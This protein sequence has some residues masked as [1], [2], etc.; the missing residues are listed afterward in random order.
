M[1]PLVAPALERL[2]EAATLVDA[3]QD[4][5]ERATIL[6][7]LLKNH[8]QELAKLYRTDGTQ[9]EAVLI[10]MRAV[11]G[12][13]GLLKQWLR[14]IKA[15]AKAQAS[16]LDARAAYET[17]GELASLDALVEPL[18]DCPALLAPPR[19]RVVPG[20]I[21]CGDDQIALEPIVV[22][23]VTRDLETS[24]IRWD[25]AWRWRG[26][27]W[28]RSV[29]RHHALDSRKLMALA[30]FGLPVNSDNSGALVRY[31]A[32]FEA[33]NLPLVGERATTARMGWLGPRVFQLGPQCIGSDCVL[34][35][36]GGLEE[37]GKGWREGG[38][39]ASWK[40]AIY[41]HLRG[42]PLVQLALYGAVATPLLAILEADGFIMDWSGV[43]S[44][45]K[46]SALRVA[47]SVW[48]HPDTL[49][50]SWATASSVGPQETAAF[51]H[52]LPVILDDTQRVKDR[53]EIV[54]GMLYDIPAGQ[55]KTRGKA[56]GGL[57]K[58]KTW[59]TIMLSTGEKAVIDF[60]PDAGARARSLCI[61][62]A[63]FGSDTTANRISTEA[64]QASLRRNYGHL[65]PL[66]LRHLVDDCNYDALRERWGEIRD[67]YGATAG[68]SVS[69]RLAASV[70]VLGLAAELVHDL[71]CPGRDQMETALDVAWAAAQHSGEDSDRPAAA[72]R[73][74]YNWANMHASRFEGATK[75]TKDES[76]HLG[77]AGK[78]RRTASS[79]QGGGLV[80]KQ[81]SIY[82]QVAKPVLAKAGYDVDYV[83]NEW[84]R[85]GFLEPSGGATPKVLRRIRVAGSFGW[86][87]VFTPD[88]VAGLLDE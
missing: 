35:A 79:H 59:R 5:A 81:L 6:A 44:R 7:S 72:F 47:A 83:L 24:A 3:S 20:G 19:Y 8:D 32:E 69:R 75:S 71:G 60:S 27:W 42:R 82:P 64:L 61:R 26:K 76:P 9:F 12:M 73:T 62:G 87:W 57:R 16:R 23:G 70:A 40:A 85:R 22:T 37:L 13:A 17:Q 21:W 68:G 34:T 80:W 52:S 36:D 54:A 46:T 88:S 56:G 49:V 1:P 84:T 78:W 28:R 33:A 38:L 45:G 86:L 53:P 43:T 48:G 25:M 67:K 77:W 11:H 30:E 74:L 10:R 29:E 18:G 63:P 15:L 4:A 58:T 55:E 14:P 66:L 39:W 2:E 50:R 65:G 31:L 41:R 51:L